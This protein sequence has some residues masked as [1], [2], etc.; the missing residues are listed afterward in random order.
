MNRI[1]E[2]L[3]ENERVELLVKAA[4]NTFGQDPLNVNRFLLDNQDNPHVGPLA[5]ARASEEGLRS[6]LKAL[7]AL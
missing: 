7:E 6:G 2:M 4:F 1:S 3:R 5:E